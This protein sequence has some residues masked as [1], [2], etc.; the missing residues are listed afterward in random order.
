MSAH[1]EQAT[2]RSSELRSARSEQKAALRGQPLQTLV[3][4][5]VNPTRELATYSIRQLF[6]GKHTSGVIRRVNSATV[7]RAIRELNKER[8]RLWHDGLKLGELTERERR[9]LVREILRA[10]GER[11]LRESVRMS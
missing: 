9:R 4:A 3:P 7:A 11:F 6:T 5:L 8:M 10:A 2:R 1:L